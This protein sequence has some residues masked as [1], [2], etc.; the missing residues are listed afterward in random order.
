[1][2]RMGGLYRHMPI[3]WLCSVIGTL[4]LVGFPGFAGFF[5]KDAIIEAVHLS[6]RFG[7]GVAVLALKAGVFVTALYSFRLL[8]LVFH[9]Q[10]RLAHGGDTHD[11]TAG[12]AAHVAIGH[13][14]HEGHAAHATPQESPWVVTGPL[15]ALAVPSIFLGGIL[16]GDM[17]F[18]DYFGQSIYVAP[19]NQ[20][21]KEMAEEYHGA[22]SFT[23]HGFFS[24]PFFLLVG[25]AYVA[26]LYYLVSPGKA[27]Q[28]T[29]AW[30]RLYALLLNKYGFDDFNN[31]VFA[32]GARLGG[33]LLSHF[34]DGVVIDGWL[35]NGSAKVVG[36]LAAQVRWIQTGY[37]YHYAFAMIL[38]LLCLLTIA[39][40]VA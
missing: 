11:D 38:G 7:A 30:P 20:V 2:R 18:G 6:H 17:L 22:L 23:L 21:L 29:A 33:G 15:L 3:T 35:V 39:L 13:D 4:A 36:W 31:R 34:G 27:A 5:S 19:E 26:Y 10:E 28:I 24:L 14:G 8:F 32:A 1:M 9:G 40:G 25:G 12:H 37:L 16:A